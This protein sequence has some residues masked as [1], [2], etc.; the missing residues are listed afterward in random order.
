MAFP[1]HG[2]MQVGNAVYQPLSRG[3]IAEARQ[4]LGWHLVSRNISQLSA[5]QVVAATIESLE[6]NISDGIVA[7]LIYY[8]F[9]GIPGALAYRFLNTLD[10]M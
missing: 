9:W 1:L 7:P 5:S 3:D 10:S 6:E 2:L 4:Q 8:A